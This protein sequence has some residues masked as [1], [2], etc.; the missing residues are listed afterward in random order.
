MKVK[1]YDNGNV[2]TVLSKD[3]SFYQLQCIS[4]KQRENLGDGIHVT[5]IE[6]VVWIARFFDYSFIT[7][8]D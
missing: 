7:I 5:H 4:F 8:N 6:Q 1:M 3:A 2:Y